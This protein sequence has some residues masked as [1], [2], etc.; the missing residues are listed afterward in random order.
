VRLKCLKEVV[1]N[2][3]RRVKKPNLAAVP[4]TGD[5]KDEE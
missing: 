3:L 2:V 4:S 5:R 1:A